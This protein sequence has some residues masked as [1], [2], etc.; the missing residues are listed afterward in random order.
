MR[1]YEVLNSTHLNTNVI[2][3]KHLKAD[4]TFTWAVFEDFVLVQL[5]Q[6][7]RITHSSGLH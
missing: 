1:S 3:H 7:T 6:T 4:F 2:R 5:S